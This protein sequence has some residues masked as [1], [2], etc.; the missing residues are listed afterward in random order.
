MASKAKIAQMLAG[1]KTLYPQYYNNGTDTQ[2]LVNLWAKLLED[3]T[4]EQVSVGL[5][6]AMKVCKYP[7]TPAEVIE[8]IERMISALL[9]TPAQE[10]EALEEALERVYKHSDKIGCY[11]SLNGTETLDDIARANIQTIYDKLDPATQEYVGSTKGLM[12]MADRTRDSKELS[13]E[14]NRYLKALPDMRK[15]KAEQ[16]LLSNTTSEVKKLT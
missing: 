9:P 14:R 7:P 2:M 8:Q 1:V 15:R 16:R 12:A 11:V 3:Y 6:A 5:Y 10:W 13:I 4:D